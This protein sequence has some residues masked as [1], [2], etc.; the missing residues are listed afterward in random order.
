MHMPP[1]WDPTLSA[2]SELCP[3]CVLTSPTLNSPMNLCDHEAHTSWLSE[4]LH[5]GPSPW[6]TQLPPQPHPRAETT[7]AV[8]VSPKLTDICAHDA[9]A[10]GI[11]FTCESLW[12]VSDDV[13]KV[14][15]GPQPVAATL[16][17][18][19]NC[20][21]LFPVKIMS[22]SEMSQSKQPPDGFLHH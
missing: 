22:S 20:E 4:P 21:K 3:L 18:R 13:F 8:N 12:T 10:E 11:I 9:H 7:E 6:A 17:D 2:V 16:S 19:E 1:T 5:P 14:A 15:C